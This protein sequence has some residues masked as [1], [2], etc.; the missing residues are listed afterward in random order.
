M[1]KCIVID[2]SAREHCWIIVPN[3]NKCQPKGTQLISDK[4]ADNRVG[5]NR[6][7]KNYRFRFLSSS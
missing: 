5:M 1:Q 6:F 7:L 2:F 4:L 3:N